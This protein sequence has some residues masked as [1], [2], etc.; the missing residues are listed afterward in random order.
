[1]TIIMRMQRYKI[2]WV[3]LIGGVVGLLIFLSPYVLKSKKDHDSINVTI[4]FLLIREKFTELKVENPSRN[5]TAE[6]LELSLYS[7]WVALPPET[8]LKDMLCR[9][10]VKVSHYDMKSRKW[11]KVMCYFDRDGNFCY[12]ND[13]FDLV[14][15]IRREGPGHSEG[16]EGRDVTLKSSDVLD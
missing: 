10:T 1:M 14:K 15:I 12:F 5:I 3:V 2:V 7:S 11:V 4:E 8:E 13:D 9:A 6:D 16:R